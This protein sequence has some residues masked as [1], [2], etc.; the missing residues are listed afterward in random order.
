MKNPIISAIFF[1]IML[2]SAATTFAA[3][4]NNE[5]P[6]VITDNGTGYTKAGSII[7]D[8]NI[9]IVIAAVLIVAIVVFAIICI[10]KKSK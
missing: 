3:E 4:N 5:K 7:S 9:W 8:G 1:L 6:S 10:S 2:M